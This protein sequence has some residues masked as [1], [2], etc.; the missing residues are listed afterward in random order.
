MRRSML[1]R[2]CAVVHCDGV[3]RPTGR[4]QEMHDS[5]NYPESPQDSGL[6]S[7]IL[8]VAS[9]CLKAP[10]APEALLGIGRCGE[11][12]DLSIQR[13]NEKTGIA[14]IAILLRAI[15]SNNGH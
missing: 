10:E 3:V 14:V 7:S 4:T 12:R 1:W 6:T 15:A 5:D 9:R 8:G 2:S 11:W 13:F